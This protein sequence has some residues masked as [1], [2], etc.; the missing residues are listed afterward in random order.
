MLGDRW[1][2]LLGW[3]AAALH[4]GAR[5]RWIGWTSLQRRQR[6][7]LVANN[8]RFLILPEAQGT[9]RLAS[10]A[11]GLSLRRLPRDWQRLH[12]HALLL[13]ESF[14]DPR[15]FAGT[16]YR[17]ANWIEVGATLG[18]GRVRGGAIGYVSH[19]APKR[20]FVYPLRSDA[21]RQLAAERPHPDWRPHR[22]H[23]MLNDSQLS[24]LHAYLSQVPDTRK[25]R[26]LRY[27]L[28]TALT[29][30]LASRLAGGETLTD[31]ADF[32]RALSQDTLR[33]IGSRRRPQ[34]GRYEAPGIS[35]WH[36]ILK[37]IDAAEAERL[38][39]AWSASQVLEN[40]EDEDD[41]GGAGGSPPG[42]VAI[43]GKVLRG[44]YNR[45]LDDEGK[46]RDE[47]AQQQ[48]SAVDIGT[49]AVVGQLG[50]SGQKDAAEG[51]ALRTLVETWQG[52]G[53]CVVAD[54]LHT[55]R[56]TAQRLVDLDLHFLLTVKRNQPTLFAQLHEDYR[57]T[58]C[59]YSDFDGG[60][61]RIERRTIRV[62][63]DLADCPEWLGFPGVR[64][65]AQVKRETVFKKSGRQRK[66]ETVY[67]VT[68]LP[69]ERATPKQ[70][71]ALNR[72]YWGAVENGVH[73]VRDVALGED[74]C[75]VRKGSLPRPAVYP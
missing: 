44:S 40:T 60:H 70:L 25:R 72:S 47:P 10:R 59:A 2:A 30:L 37:D 27:P 41:D 31:L 5:D 28:P 15:L 6:L 75:R 55:Q 46:E 11:L 16:C 17:A 74:A 52:T 57:W 36:Y 8:S 9:P 3:H 38:L 34:T 39:A 12:R 58:Q 29:L 56:Q 63:E 67:L 26:G 48:L 1:L 54:A 73:Y 4:C 35:S 62:S 53:I 45:D 24:S 14:V 19:G 61:G 65:V 69:P 18:F 22:P 33:L 51:A 13:A 71:L 43:D 68:S 50:F 32:G 23:I 42:A 7:F 66:P 64:F 49:G 21:R 20:V